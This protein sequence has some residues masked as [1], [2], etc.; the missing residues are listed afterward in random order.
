MSASL[1]INPMI[2]RAARCALEEAALE[3][4]ALAVPLEALMQHVI[5]HGF[6]DFFDAK[7]DPTSD[8][9]RFVLRIPA[10]LN[11]RITRL[12]KGIVGQIVHARPARVIP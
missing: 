8:A 5:A 1:D 7:V 4:E 2:A 9:F 10:D 11:C 3:Q 6:A 12:A